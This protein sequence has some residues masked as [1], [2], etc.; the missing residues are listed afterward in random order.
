MQILTQQVWSGAQDSALLTRFHSMARS[1]G[2][3]EEQPSA[4]VDRGPSSWF[5]QHEA[6]SVVPAKEAWGLQ[7]LF[8][9]DILSVT[10]F[11]IWGKKSILN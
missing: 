9:K 7:R 2:D 8:S 10:A 6:P 5:Y 1:V 3:I 11:M 4:C